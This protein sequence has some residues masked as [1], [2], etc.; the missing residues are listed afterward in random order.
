MSSRSDARDPAFALSDALCEAFARHCPASATMAGLPCDGAAWNDWS[1]VG[2]AAWGATLG[3]FEERLRELRPAAPGDHWGTVARQVMA[4]Y[5]A[6][7]L[8]EQV[9][10]EHL[11]DLNNIES[12]LQ[13]LRVVF[14]MMDTGSPEGWDA[15][16]ARLETIDG[17]AAGYRA[18][19]EEGRRTGRVVARRQ[20]LAA[21]EQAAHQAGPGSFFETLIPAAAGVARPAVVERLPAAVEGARRTF[22]D[23]HGYLKETYL[24]SATEV[25]GVGE[26][27]YLRAARRFLGARI[28]PRETYAW[29]WSEVA[30]IEAA[31]ARL[32]EEIMPGT[33]VPEVIR[34]LERDPSRCAGSVEE[35]LELMRA[36]QEKALADL[37]GG[38]FDVPE[39][40]RRIEVRLAPPGGP[41]GASYVPP[42]E[43]FARPGTIWYSPGE[44]TTIPL[45]GEITTAYHEGF[46]GHHL[47][48]G[49]Q[50]C[51]EGQLSRLHRFLVM[52]SGY[53]EGWAL[54][55][56]QLMHE[57]GYFEKPEYVLGML[58]AKL[59][60]A[61][62]VVIDIGMHLDLPIP[63]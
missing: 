19:L 44:A 24:P 12:T 48:C 9:H 43:G 17:A 1:P 57:L 22:A 55:A 35:F 33:P 60:R 29:G 18:S 11:R 5:L 26:E 2:V 3:S 15:V 53:A 58:A 51:L 14:D 6:E 4:G 23:L 42:S 16:L 27:R 8:D 21:M 34:L 47:Q 54:Y 52:Y 63:A 31:M 20:V 45:W 37:E 28:D 10:A 61:Y 62:R 30:S 13:H 39:P 46:P 56:E 7:R 32:G 25:D 41:L 59:M 49:L 36:R 40:I 50:V 38:H